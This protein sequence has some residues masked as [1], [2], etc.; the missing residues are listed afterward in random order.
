M[1][2]PTAPDKPTKMIRNDAL[3]GLRGIAALIV[4]LG[5]ISNQG[6]LPGWMGHGFE[7]IGVMIFFVL[8]AYLM[9]ELYL[10]KDFRRHNIAYATARIGRVFP[11][12]YAIVL[13]SLFFTGIS[14]WRYQF[15]TLLDAVLALCMI[16]APYEL[17]AVPV[18]VQF[19]LLF[20]VI[21]MTRST[22]RLL[23][24]RLHLCITLFTVWIVCVAITLAK[25]KAGMEIGGLNLYIHFFIIGM[26]CSVF[27]DSII[28][29]LSTDR[30][31]TARWVLPVLAIISL[32]ACIQPLRATFHVDVP[33]RGDPVAVLASFF[34]FLSTVNRLGPFDWLGSKFMV[35]L[36]DISYGFYLIH[37]IV[38]TALITYFR[39]SGGLYE[40][41]IILVV[42][43]IIAQFSL[44]A[45]ER[46]ASR[47]IRSFGNTTN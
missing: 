37:H 41:A 12:Y 29:F 42:T 5:H 34:V 30:H 22:T 14:A 15:P 45:F 44:Y 47:L 7:Q 26:L 18:E 2:Q 9:T 11:L 39:P 1:T 35:W 33:T 6:L 17:W 40:T 3:T 16:S 10:L 43:V 23:K 8:S 25:R 28:S 24:T 20:A 21:W 13:I 32:I 38:L 27:S 4:A 36:G 46:P 19:Y 31:K